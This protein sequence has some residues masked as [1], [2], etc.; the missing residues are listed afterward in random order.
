MD[1]QRELVP[2]WVAFPYIPWLSD[3]WKSGPGAFFWWQWNGWFR[4][5]H[6]SARNEYKEKFPEPT[7][8]AGFY[9]T[10]KTDEQSDF[11]KEH[12]EI[13]PDADN[14]REYYE[15]CD[16]DYKGASHDP[17]ERLV[18]LIL[19]EA[20]AR[21]FNEIE[22]DD[23]ELVCPV[24]FVRGNERLEIDPLPKRLFGAFK[25]RVARM[26]GKEDDQG[27]GTFV[28]SLN[29]ADTSERDYGEATVSVVFGDSSLRL[30]IINLTAP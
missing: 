22:I 11:I 24:R 3:G 6:E 16:S 2:P 25:G 10:T 21:R 30:T 13:D 17:L 4:A 12:S 19:R 15:T 8:W 7:G 26:C 9:E 14:I 5:L 23:R 28:A 27:E 29:L 18:I 1:E 20:V